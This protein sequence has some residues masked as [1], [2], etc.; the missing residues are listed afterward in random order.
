MPFTEKQFYARMSP[1]A[2]RPGSSM[3][4]GDTNKRKKP[5]KDKHS[6]WRQ[7]MVSEG[8]CPHCGEPCEPFY[9]C[10][11]RRVNKKINLFLRQYATVVGKDGSSNIYQK[12]N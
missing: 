6:R 9:E 10:A 2:D 5:A 4:R 8:K 7:K 1:L 3:P 11:N 12:K